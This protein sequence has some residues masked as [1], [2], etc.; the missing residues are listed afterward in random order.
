MIYAIVFPLADEGVN[1]V[2][3]G[4]KSREKEVVRVFDSCIQQFINLKP[5]V[6]V[7]VDGQPVEQARPSTDCSPT[8][9]FQW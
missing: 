6:A 5:Y 2:V 1:V 4:Q 7:D 3:Q 9:C 8:C